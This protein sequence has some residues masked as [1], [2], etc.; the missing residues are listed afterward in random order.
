MKL[1]LEVEPHE[2]Q[3]VMGI[4]GI[5]AGRPIPK[6]IESQRPATSGEIRAWAKARKLPVSRK[7]KIPNDVEIMFYA[8]RYT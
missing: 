1:T 6:Q 3:E 2:L 5:G 8:E 4:I 7:G